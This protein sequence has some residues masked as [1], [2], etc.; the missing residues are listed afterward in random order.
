MCGHQRRVNPEQSLRRISTAPRRTAPQRRSAASSFDRSLAWDHG[1]SHHPGS[2]RSAWPAQ[3]TL[4]TAVGPAQ[5]TRGLDPWTRKLLGWSPPKR[6]AQVRTGI[7]VQCR[8]P[9]TP[10]VVGVGGQL[11]GQ[12][13]GMLDRQAGWGSGRQ[14][15][16]GGGSPWPTPTAMTP[17]CTGT[18]I[19][20]SPS[21]CGMASSG[22]TWTPAT[23]ASTTTPPS[24]TPPG[25]GQR[26]RV[27]RIGPVI[28]RCVAVVPSPK[29]RRVRADLGSW[30][31]RHGLGTRCAETTQSDY[32]R[33][34]G[35]VRMIVLF[36]PHA[37]G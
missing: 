8:P 22:S 26:R 16:A 35:S 2:R 24:A 10:V 36:V 25:P 30:P 5:A 37:A 28:G 3:A 21:S 4:M 34:L 15:H 6:S 1:R 20:T 14:G 27:L 23:T 13:G 7:A 18:S 17:R 33:H 11:G 9:W 12:P 32:G 29:L 19:P 31:E